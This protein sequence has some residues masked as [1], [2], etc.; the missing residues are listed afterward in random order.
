MKPFMNERIRLGIES[1]A[2]GRHK[3]KPIEETY[4]KHAVQKLAK[5]TGVENVTVHK[6][7]NDLFVIGRE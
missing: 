2:Y 3:T 7:D 5:L 6:L 4:L 1:R